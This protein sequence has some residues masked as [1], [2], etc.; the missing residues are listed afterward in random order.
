M[1]FLGR[2]QEIEL[3]R[4]WTRKTDGAFLSVIYGRRRIGKSRL[5][6][7]AFKGSAFLKFE[8]I[9]GQ[10]QGVQ[11]KTFLDRLAEV[12]GRREYRMLRTS[13]WTDILTCLSEYLATRAAME[14]V[15]V[16]LDEFQWMAAGRTQ[17]VSS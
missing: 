4:D 17:L 10:P 16:L 6:E 13:S 14:P 12:S 3:L 7:E 9:E 2:S 8:G 15:V 11:Q 5:V 1:D